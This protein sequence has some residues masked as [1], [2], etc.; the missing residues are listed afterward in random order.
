MPDFM[1]RLAGIMK[2]RHVGSV[3]EFVRQQRWEKGTV[4]PGRCVDG[5]ATTSGKVEISSSILE[6]LG[7][8]PIPDY[9]EPE[10]LHGEWGKYPLL[11]LSGVR[12]IP[13]H[14]SEFRHVDGFRRMHPDPIVEQ[15]VSPVKRKLTKQEKKALRHKLEKA[16]REREGR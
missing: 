15:L 7:Y 11:N 1:H 13:Y 8:D 14:H 2:E 4:R 9:T 6:K 3:E 16:R 12:T 5:L 10:A